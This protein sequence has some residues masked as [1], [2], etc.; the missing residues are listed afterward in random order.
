[1]LNVRQEILISRV[2]TVACVPLE[3]FILKKVS[4][5]LSEISFK[6][7][8]IS[9]RTSLSMIKHLR[10]SSVVRQKNFQYLKKISW[11][12]LTAPFD[13]YAYS[14]RALSLSLESAAQIIN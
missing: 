11:D 1:M 12:F 7:L 5:I 4:A 6:V 2:L 13:T 8:P 9:G 14:K 10:I 3:I